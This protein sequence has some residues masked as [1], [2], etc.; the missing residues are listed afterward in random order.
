MVDRLFCPP[1]YPAQVPTSLTKP[2]RVARRNRAGKADQGH[3]QKPSLAVHAT[4]QPELLTRAQSSLS[5][6]TYKKNSL[7]FLFLPFFFLGSRFLLALSFSLSH[8][9]QNHPPILGRKNYL[10]ICEGKRGFGIQLDPQ[11]VSDIFALRIWYMG[12]FYRPSWVNKTFSTHTCTM[13]KILIF[14]V[15]FFF[16][17]QLCLTMVNEMYNK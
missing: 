6:C 1:P 15:F 10:C 9:P 8:P 16:F 12:V 2:W 4:S 5:L 11:C 14:F 13:T 17:F 7:L 3:K